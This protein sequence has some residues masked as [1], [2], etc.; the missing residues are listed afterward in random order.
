MNSEIQRLVPQRNR[1]F[2]KNLPNYSKL[3]KL[4]R[5]DIE[6]KEIIISVQNSPVGICGDGVS[7]NNKAARLLSELYGFQCPSYQCSAHTCDGTVKRPARSKAMSVAEIKQCYESLS[8]TV[9]NFS[10]AWKTKKAW[11]KQRKCCKWHFHL[12]SWCATHM[13]HFLDACVICDDSLVPLQNTLMSCSVNTEAR[14]RFFTIKNI[15]CL[16][17]LKHLQV[18]LIMG[19]LRQV[20]KSA[21]LVKM[22]FM[23]SKETAN[24]TNHAKT[25][26]ADEFLD[27]MATFLPNW[28]L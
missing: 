9:K 23:A 22:L 17:L 13:C 12:L 16:K 28:Q 5:L 14:D 27:K 1:D 24:K 21:A 7:C 11:I 4:K 25:P 20:E 19:Y 15:K 10:L 8:P 2:Q 26:S 3:G 18:K 6:N